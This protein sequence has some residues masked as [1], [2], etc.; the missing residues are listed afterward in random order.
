MYIV[1]AIVVMIV[2][3]I[4]VVI[5]IVV[6]IVNCHSVMIVV[7]ELVIA[8]RGAALSRARRRR[9]R[10][11]CAISRTGKISRRRMPPPPLLLLLPQTLQNK[12]NKKGNLRTKKKKI[13]VFLSLNS[14]IISL[15]QLVFVYLHL[16][17]FVSLL[18]SFC[19]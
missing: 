14:F 7:F 9:W 2:I 3:V 15:L 4:M 19:V 18:F 6:V 10:A 5:V 11:W 17:F 13:G 1:T 12:E 8:R 16:N